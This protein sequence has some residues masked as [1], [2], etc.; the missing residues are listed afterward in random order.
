MA[1]SSPVVCGEVNLADR[2]PL[3]QMTIDSLGT[4]DLSFRSSRAVHLLADIARTGLWRQDDASS[5]KLQAHG[6]RSL[7][8]IGTSRRYRGTGLSPASSRLTE[9]ALGFREKTCAIPNSPY[10]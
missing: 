4:G 9:P 7:Q 3:H 6:V 5:R 2:P 1:V 10:Y 8:P